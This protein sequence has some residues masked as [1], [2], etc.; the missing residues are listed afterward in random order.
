MGLILAVF[1]LAHSAQK[2]D[3]PIGKAALLSAI[4]PGS[5]QLVYGARNRGEAMLW[6]DGVMWMSWVSFSWYK[7]SKEQDARLIARRFAN[8]EISIKDPAYYRALERYNNSEEYNE[9]IRRFA[10]ELYPDDPDAQRRYYESHGYFGNKEWRWASD[11]I[12]IYSYYQTMKTARTA[13]MTAS[14]FAAGLVLNRLIS[15]FDC[16]F[17]LPDQ[18]IADRVEVK[19]VPDH[20]GIV[21][22]WRF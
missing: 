12:R 10:R 21:L 2:H 5:G 13:G 15:I 4:L 14:F 16:L 18:G 3:F 19:P 7:T 11:S 1:I 17:F 8:A 20:S 9:D 6:T 22:C